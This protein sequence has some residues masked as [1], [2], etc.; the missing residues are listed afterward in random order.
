[1]AAR[2]TSAPA[3]LRYGVLLA[4]LIVT[5]AGCAASPAPRRIA[6]LAPFESRYREIGYDALY[7][8]RLALQDAGTTKI[9]LLPVDDGGSAAHAADRARALARDPL[10]AAVLVLGPDATTPAALNA[11]DDLPVLVVGNWG[12][13]PVHDRVFILSSPALEDLLTIPPRIDITRIAQMQTPLTGG[14]MLALPQVQGLR[15]SLEGITL[16]SSATPPDADFIQHYRSSD[17]FAPEP[18]LLAPLT[19]D[20]TALLIH[21]LSQPADDRAGVYQALR[22]TAYTG[23]N[24]VIQFEAGYW[25]DAPIHAYAYSP[26]GAL[27]P[28]DNIVEQR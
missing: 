5:L 4:L 2:R 28:I 18:G 21:S 27:L 14:D 10:V 13:S 7:A 23:L 15:A 6:L 11:F 8:A 25:Q 20:A 17:P 19:Y 3:A 9:E 16:V 1:M 22:E 12:A 26:D 24:G